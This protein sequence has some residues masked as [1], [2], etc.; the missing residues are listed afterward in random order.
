[1]GFAYN[2]GKLASRI[3]APKLFLA[4]CV[5]VVV[6]L[7]VISNSPDGRSPGVAA[8]PVSTTTEERER[9]QQAE[10]AEALRVRTEQCTSGIDAVFETVRKDLQLDDPRMADAR[11]SRCDG[12]ANGKVFLALK[13]STATA[14]KAQNEK[15]KAEELR[16]VKAEKARKK[17]EGVRVGMSQAEV[18]E[19]SWGRPEK[20]N[21]TTT[22][23]GDR[24]QWVYGIGNYLYFENGI[25]TTIQNSR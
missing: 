21:T 24:E 15:R 13:R 16:V 5:A 1:M 7:V 17:S 3:G 18:L 10:A 12:I 6:V 11:L 9:Q 8:V 2:A 4:G 19:S 23:R 22:R 25:L 14:L 20:I